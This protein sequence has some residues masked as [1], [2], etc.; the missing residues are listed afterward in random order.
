VLIRSPALALAAVLVLSGSSRAAAAPP[1]SPPSPDGWPRTWETARGTFAV[2][3]P[4]LDS[5]DGRV[6]E[7]HSAASAQAPGEKE[8][9][10]FGVL[11]FR[12]QT[13]VDKLARVVELQDLQVTKA[14]FPSL[15][16]GG[17]GMVAVYQALVPRKP[18]VVALDRLESQLAILGAERKGEAQQVR[19]DPPRIVFA[20][21]A[22]ALV[23]IDGAPAWRPVEK[24]SL[25]RVLNTR[26]LVLRDPAKGRVWVHVLDGWV[27]A[28]SLA[29]PWAV[30][31]DAPKDAN[32]IAKEAAKSGAVDLMQGPE[33]PKTKKRPSLSAGMPLVVVSEVP[34]EVIHFDGKPAWSSIEGTNLLYVANTTANVFRDLATQ[35]VLVLLSGRWFASSSMDGPWA[36]VPGAELPPDF[37]RIPDSSPKENVKASVPGTR[38]AQEALIAAQIPQTATVYREKAKFKPTVS[39]TPVLKPVE[40]TDLLYVFNSP[41]PIIQVTPTQWYALQD[42]VWF[43]APALQGPWVV[44][45][46][47]PAV[48]YSIPVSSPIHYVTYVRI[49][50]YTPTQVVVG[51]TPGYL[52]TVVTP[53]GVVVYGTGYVYPA[54]VGPTVWYGPPPTYGYGV[55]VTYTP[56]TGWTFG[57]MAVGAAWY[58]PPPYW[59][60]MRPPYYYPYPRPMP[61]GAAVG[62][63]GG[64]AAWGPGGWA[65][66][67]GNVYSSWGSTSAVTRNSAGYNAWTGNAWATQSGRSYNSATGQISAGQ[68]GAVQNVYT[69]NY[70]SGSRGA[71]YNPSTGV[72]AAGQKATVGNA[73]TG[74]E[75]TAGRGVVSGPGGN[76][77]SVAGV[78][79]SGGGSVYR[80][81]DSYY[82]TKDGNVYRSNG[83]GGYEQVTPKGSGSS[84]LSSSQTRS[85]QQQEAARQ[86]GTQRASSAY[87]G[88]SGWGGRSGS[89]SYGGSWGGGGGG[90]RR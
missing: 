7:F 23:A 20:E 26:A 80:V 25:E 11:E 50:S 45:T 51:Y 68:R 73:Y 2:Y 67:S 84:T 65:A 75:V 9:S 62:P 87:G 52:G 1:A 74:N 39:G 19:N 30:A 79:G 16:D 14:T 10:T 77:T 8:P 59:G 36:F 76:T 46:S 63:Y 66:T 57:F 31:K 21:T 82:G 32:K 78:Q 47:V 34:T 6:L 12:A 83:Q 43:T 17:A 72:A 13:L 61:Y 42:A 81:G 33:D 85:L 27:G 5:W 64:A 3:P 18:P 71:T 41:D 40:G 24:T 29:G 70:A 53:A 86:Q 89:G 60:P 90:R 88:S 58:A 4:Q 48:V 69:G 44:A 22:A 55:N 38:Q 56:W 28:A 54:Y 37:A 15:P 35:K 49:Y